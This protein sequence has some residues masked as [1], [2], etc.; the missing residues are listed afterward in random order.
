ME[1]E[2]IL[3]LKSTCFLKNHQFYVEYVAPIFKME[4][5]SQVP[6]DKDKIVL[7]FFRLKT[8]KTRLNV[9]SR[10]CIGMLIWSNVYLHG[11]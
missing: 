5:L 11:L 6:I 8:N 3:T 2:L 1:V 9:M 7:L 4:V 10:N